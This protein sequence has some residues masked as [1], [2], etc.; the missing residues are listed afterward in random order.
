MIIDHEKYTIN[1]LP[2]NFNKLFFSVNMTAANKQTY[3]NGIEK[4]REK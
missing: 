4:K 2:G 1:N 3:F